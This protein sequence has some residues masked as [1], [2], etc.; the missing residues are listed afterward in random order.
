[1]TTCTDRCLHDATTELDFNYHD[2]VAHELAHQWWGD[3]LTP[4]SWKHTWLKESFATYAE[5]L[6]LEHVKGETEARFNMI[7]DANVYLMED[8]DRYR[9][10]VVYGQYDFPVE[11]YDR[12]TYEKGCIVLGMLRYVLG[13]NDFF[14]TLT[15]YAHKHEWQSVE[16]NDFKVAIEEVTGQNLD[17]FFDSGCTGAAIPSLK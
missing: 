6:W 7:Q 9:R 2:I 14:R 11:I 3:L 4:K 15:H 16:T 10:P 17:W 13:T 8:R 12:H 1:M 5:A